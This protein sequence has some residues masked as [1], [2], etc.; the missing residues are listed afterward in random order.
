MA[1][2]V[3]R[4][5]GSGCERAT[6]GEQQRTPKGC[7]GNGSNLRIKSGEENMPLDTH[8]MTPNTESGGKVRAQIP[9]DSTEIDA[10]GHSMVSTAGRAV[11]AAHGEI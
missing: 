4:V 11:G 5:A 8:G 3:R 1:W 6:T 9:A 10:R 2:S 7:A